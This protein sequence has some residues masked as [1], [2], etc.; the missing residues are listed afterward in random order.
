MEQRSLQMKVTRTALQTGD[1]DQ[2]A[3][4]AQF[5]LFSSIPVGYAETTNM[6]FRTPSP[7]VAE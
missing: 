1:G 3:K 7:H 2:A 4:V 5:H 6:V